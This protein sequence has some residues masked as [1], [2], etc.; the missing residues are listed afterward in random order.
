MPELLWQ[1]MEREIKRLREQAYW[2]RYMIYSQMTH[3]L[4]QEDLEDSPFSKFIRDVL[5]RRNKYH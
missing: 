3:H 4:F 1:A 2:N 5:M